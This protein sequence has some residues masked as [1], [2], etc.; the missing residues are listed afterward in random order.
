M[1]DATSEADVED[2]MMQ[3]QSKNRACGFL[4]QQLDVK[5]E[6]NSFKESATLRGATGGLKEVG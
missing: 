3:R 2:P 6:K 1:E 4:K 5:G